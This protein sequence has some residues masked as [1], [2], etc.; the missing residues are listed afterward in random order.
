[1]VVVDDDACCGQQTANAPYNSTRRAPT[2]QM[3]KHCVYML[4]SSTLNQQRLYLY[5]TDML[6]IKTDCVHFETCCSQLTQC[7][8]SI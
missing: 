6:F 3:Q 7:L 1:M 2:Q 5:C 8:E 4:S